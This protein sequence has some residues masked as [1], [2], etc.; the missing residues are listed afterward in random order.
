[1]EQPIVMGSYGIGP[2]RIVAA[3]I[4]QRADERGIV[5]PPALAPWQV[6]LVSLAKAGEPEREAADRLYEELREAGVEVLYDDRDAGAGGE[7]DRRRAARLPAADRRRPPRPRRRRRRGLRARLRR[8]ARAARGG[9]RRAGAVR[10]SRASMPEPRPLRPRPRAPP[11]RPRPQ[12]PQTAAGPA[13]ASRS[14]PGRSPT[15]SATCA[16]RR[17]RSSSSSPTPATTAPPSPPRWSSGR[18]PPATTS[19]A[20]SPASPASTAA[21]GRCWTRWSTASRSSPAPS[22]AGASS[23]C[24]AGRWRVLAL[25][26]LAMLFLAQYGLRH[27]VDIEVNWPGRISVFPI[28]GGIL[29][30]LF[31]P[32]WVATALVVWGTGDGDPRHR[33]LRPDRHA[34]GA[35][36]GLQAERPNRANLQPSVE[37]LA[38]ARPII[39][40][41]ANGGGCAS[42]D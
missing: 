8:R 7:A 34:R 25:R 41:C 26:E 36:R 32:G 33:A 15:W 3:A 12:R 16:W 31:A 39:V 17:C 42:F 13:R 24:R 29:L 37:P 28:M 20:S 5:W 2:A 10:F 21:W 11:L 22:S 1:M 38:H 4:E 40:A 30:A 9:G 23:C 18:S 6:H 14:T 35:R 27:G 19:T